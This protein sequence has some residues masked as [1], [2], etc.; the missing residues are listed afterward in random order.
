MVG[1]TKGEVNLEG[2]LDGMGHGQR[3]LVGCSHGVTKSW[4]WLSTSHT[5]THTHTMEKNNQLD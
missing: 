1:I 2:H 5:H 4:T 3:R